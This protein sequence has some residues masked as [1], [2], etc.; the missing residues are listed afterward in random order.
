[1]GA[2]AT[3]A[4]YG[5]DRFWCNVRTHTLH[6]PLAYKAREVGNFQVNGLITPDPLYT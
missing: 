3:A 6:D 4:Q 1:M 5:F 2:R